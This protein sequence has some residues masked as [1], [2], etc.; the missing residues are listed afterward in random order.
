MNIMYIKGKKLIVIGKSPKNN[1]KQGF[2]NKWEGIEQFSH[3]F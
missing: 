1:D 2:E 3:Q